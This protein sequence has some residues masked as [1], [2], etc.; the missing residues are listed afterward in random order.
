MKTSE[1]RQKNAAELKKER[2]E[3]LRELFNLRVQRANQ[4]LSKPHL[5]QRAR[6]DIARINTILGEKAGKA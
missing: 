4:Q 5:F 1:L 2:L 6:R 3:L